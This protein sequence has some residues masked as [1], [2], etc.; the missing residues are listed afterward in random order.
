MRNNTGF[1]NIEETDD[2]E[3]F[4]NGFPVEKVGGNKLKNN[5]KIYNITQGVQNV[6]TQ[7]SNVPL[8]KLDNQERDKYNKNLETL[9]FENYKPTRGE[10]KSG[11]Y[12]QSKSNFKKRNLQGEGVNILL[13]QKY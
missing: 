11:R 4:W 13:H 3:V 10:S 6:F 7:T 2:G 1:F 5:G 8:K 12:K 9:D